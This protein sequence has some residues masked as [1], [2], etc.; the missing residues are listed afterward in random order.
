MN[1]WGSHHGRAS[2]PGY[3]DATIDGRGDWD[4]DHTDHGDM[5][6][7]S[8]KAMISMMHKEF[9][10][11][12]SELIKEL[13]DDDYVFSLMRFTGTS[14][15]QMGMPKGPYDMHT[16]QVVRFKDGKG[17]EHWEYTNWQEMEKM[18]APMM[19]EQPKMKEEG[20]KK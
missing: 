16:V 14:N 15:G 20:K 8:L 4:A 10:D 13:G 2:D 18:M 19:K 17:V 12:K 5:G 1:P 7:D 11:M 9:P 3:G 6:R